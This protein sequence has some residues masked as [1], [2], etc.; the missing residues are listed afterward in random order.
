MNRFPVSL[1][2]ADFLCEFSMLFNEFSIDWTNKPP[3]VVTPKR[4]GFYF[5]A[6]V[7]SSGSVVFLSKG[8]YEFSSTPVPDSTSRKRVS[9][10][11]SYDNELTAP[12][13]RF[14][15]TTLHSVQEHLDPRLVN[16]TGERVTSVRTLQCEFCLVPKHGKME[17]IELLLHWPFPD[18]MSYDEI[19]SQHVDIVIYVHGCL[20]PEDDDT[21]CDAHT[22]M[23]ALERMYPV[24]PNSFTEIRVVER[25]DFANKTMSKNMDLLLDTLVVHEGV[26]CRRNEKWIRDVRMMFQREPDMVP[27]YSQ[28]ITKTKASR[29]LGAYVVGYFIEE[30]IVRVTPTTTVCHRIVSDVICA[31]KLSVPTATGKP[32]FVMVFSAK[33][34]ELFKVS[35][36]IHKKKTFLHYTNVDM[37]HNRYNYKQKH[38]LCEIYDSVMQLT[39]YDTV[40]PVDV[41]YHIE[42]DE[43]RTFSNLARMAARNGK[44]MH[45]LR[46]PIQCVLKFN[47]AWFVGSLPATMPS[48]GDGASLNVN[49]LHLQAAGIV[50]IN[51]SNPRSNS[52]I[53]FDIYNQIYENMSNVTVD[54]LIQ[55]I[56]VDRLQVDAEKWLR[57][58]TG[59]DKNNIVLYWESI[60]I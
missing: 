43:R 18:T 26:V 48:D 5:E 40:T 28:P 25:L 12:V 58:V 24:T 54:R 22:W 3:V 55:A 47:S 21:T 17:Q 32:H 50:H 39:S 37:L 20:F 33:Y 10:L 7:D 36:R 29:L 51:H 16:I 45:L 53:T 2:E 44:T 6:T 19:T 56:S 14:I 59:K 15:G 35:E 38:G 52:E 57:F 31:L 13:C 41:S 46:E 1:H 4:D 9:E 60:V 8:G 49:R 30:V 23:K 42:V 11:I 27:L 34:S